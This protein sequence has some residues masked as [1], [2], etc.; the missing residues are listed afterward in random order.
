VR[1]D[2]ITKRVLWV[3]KDESGIE[4]QKDPGD[5]KDL[6]DHVDLPDLPDLPDQL[7]LY[8]QKICVDI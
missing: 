4:V 6:L 7:G 2:I 1:T 3:K 5:Q 8:V